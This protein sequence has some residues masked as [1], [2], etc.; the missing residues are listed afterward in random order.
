[1]YFRVYAIQEL[2]QQSY[3]TGLIPVRML[4][5]RKMMDDDEMLVLWRNVNRTL[6]NVRRVML[7]VVM[8]LN[9]R[10]LSRSS[11]VRIWSPM[12]EF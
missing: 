5:R 8:R 2:G 10:T 3:M 9:A 1:M 4:I 11:S 7:L 6:L 12:F